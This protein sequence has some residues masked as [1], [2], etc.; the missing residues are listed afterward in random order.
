VVLVTVRENN[1]ADEGSVLNKIADVGDDDVD[2]EKLFLGEH[3]TGVNDNDVVIETES[4]AVHA[5][6][7]QAAERDNLQLV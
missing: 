1:G 7:A 6:L 2:A 5:E 4:E 3:E